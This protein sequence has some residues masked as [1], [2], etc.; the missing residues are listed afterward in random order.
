MLLDSSRCYLRNVELVIRVRRNII[1]Y[2]G[3]G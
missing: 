3:A 2:E 1:R